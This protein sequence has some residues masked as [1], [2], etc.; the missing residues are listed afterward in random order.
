MKGI[1]GASAL[2]SVSKR[3]QGRKYLY[4]WDIWPMRKRKLALTGEI[5][6]LKRDTDG[7]AVVSGETL[8]PFLTDE[9][10]TTRG[11][12]GIKILSDRPNQLAI[13][14]GKSGTWELGYFCPSSGVVLP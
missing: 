13:E 8:L 11:K 9:R 2:C 10:L 14:P 6:L 3:H 7:A 1:E 12:W 5:H 4:W